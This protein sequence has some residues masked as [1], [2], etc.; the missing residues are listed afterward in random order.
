MF[1]F[2]E[3][4]LR[5]VLKYIQLGVSMI[6]K[7]LPPRYL[8]FQA[9]NLLD[10]QQEGPKLQTQLFVNAAMPPSR[11]RSTLSS[12]RSFLSRDNLYQTLPEN[13]F[14]ESYWTIPR[15]A[16]RSGDFCLGSR[17]HT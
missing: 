2:E 8:L 3:K 17:R 1:S 13:A 7:Q 12:W 6:L 5:R 9:A 11:T 4:R 15:Q 14:W 16:G 10:K